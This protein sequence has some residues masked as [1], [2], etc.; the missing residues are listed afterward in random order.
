MALATAVS[1]VL[2]FFF[3]FNYPS[4]PTIFIL[5]CFSGFVVRSSGLVVYTQ[6][7]VYDM[8]RRPVL[9][10]CRDGGIFFDDDRTALREY[11]LYV[12][13]F[14]RQSSFGIKEG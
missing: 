14:N 13:P 5:W 12:R 4:G 8:L 1:T 2:L 11:D 7:V 3:L 6:V 9:C 10:G